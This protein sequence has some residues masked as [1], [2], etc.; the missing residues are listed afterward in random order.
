VSDHLPGPIVARATQ[1]GMDLAGWA[2]THRDR[3]LAEQEQGVL[4]LVREALPDLLTAVLQASTASLNA[5]QPRLRE[6]CPRCA[7]RVQR[8]S[9][10][11]RRVESICGPV[12]IERPW[13]ACRGC[14][15]GWS[16]ADRVLGLAQRGRVSAGLDEWLVRLGAATTFRDAASLLQLLTGRAMV[17][18]SVRRHAEAR[19][20][21]LAATQAA[22]IHRVEETGQ[23][24]EGPVE[25]PGV[26]LVEADGVQVRY[27]DAWH[28]VKIGL[29]AGCR[30][31]EAIAPSYVAAREGPAAFG[32]R[33]LA[34]AARRGALAVVGWQG[35]LWG[36]SLAVLRP[37]VVLGDGAPWI[38][39]LAADHFGARTEIVDFYHA[40]EHVWALATALYGP[41]T[42]TTRHWARAQT[43]RLSERG[44]DG[45]LE[46]LGRLRA[47]T[48]EAAESLRRERGYFRTNAARMNYPAY[49]A[50]GLP[51]GSGPVE[52]AGKHLVQHRL[53]R[54]GARW[55][56]AGAMAVLTLRTYLASNRPLVPAA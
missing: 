41:E 55:S 20:T 27:T 3:P 50:Q 44:A 35:G 8:Q 43:G 39:N 40:S 45:L 19:G 18:E 10:R 52:S 9:W 24:A 17:A 13:Y 56:Q 12:R 32:P 48:P 42:P 46:E 2:Q 37:V 5:Q 29:A 34:E 11:T 6:R 26:L 33:L 22:A 15:H 36:T 53:K 49:R 7:A 14:A 38:W 25:A 16:P 54:P 21:A 30:A 31:G 51:I 28:E 4:D 47:A 23:A 1:L